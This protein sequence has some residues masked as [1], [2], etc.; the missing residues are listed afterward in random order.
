MADHF[1]TE[2][3]VVVG[4]YYR[5]RSVEADRFFET[6]VINFGAAGSLDLRGPRGLRK[7][8]E[9]YRPH[10][11]HAHHTLSALWGSVLGR[12]MGVPVIVKTEHS[13]H[14]NF[15]VHQNAAN[16]V[17]LT[18]ADGVFCNSDY[19]RRSFH[20]WERR[21]AAHKCTTVYNGI[22]VSKIKTAVAQSSL[23]RAELGASSCQLLLG[24]AG[25]LV[26]QKN[27][28]RLIR[29]LALARK[30]VPSIR[31]VIA[32]DGKLRP[33]LEREAAEQ[34]VADGL[35]LLG[36]VPR[37]RVYELLGT[38]DV[39]VMPSLSE[40]FCNAAV[41]AMAAGKPIIN[42][43]IDTFREVIGPAGAFADPYSSQDMAD[44]IVRF[45]RMTPEE[46][47]R[48]GAAAQMRAQEHFTVQRTA[49]NYTKKYMELFEK[50]TGQQLG[51]L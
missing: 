29:A 40:G 42:A 7:T 14:A 21:V 48:R 33:V 8:I 19:T 32:G 34:G 51:S 45:A 17:T 37:A 12:A 20:P 36:T 5:Q 2:I 16:A 1:G 38:I 43:D 13:S 50:K 9:N 26:W 47:A 11:I 28:V 10:I 39:F 24:S 44:V 18:L 3:E 41:E 27:Y 35:L 25:R 23:S 6:P 30:E 46:R 22:D 15:G 49:Q 4:V 31:L